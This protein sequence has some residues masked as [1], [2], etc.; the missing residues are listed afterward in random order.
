M[1]Q[2]F[3]D[4]GDRTDLDDLA[5]LIE[6][7]L[8]AED[9]NAMVAP[10]EVLMEKK[11]RSCNG[12]PVGPVFID[13]GSVAS[14]HWDAKRHVTL[15]GPWVE[16]VRFVEG[17]LDFGVR[18]ADFSFPLTLKLTARNCTIGCVDDDKL[19]ITGEVGL[20]SLALSGTFGMDLD[21]GATHA[22]VQ[23]VK[24]DIDGLYL[25]LDCRPFDWICDSISDALID[26]VV[27]RLET[28]VE[29]A[30]EERGGPI[31]EEALDSFATEGKTKII[32]V[33]DTSVNV[34]VGL[35]RLT[36]CG[37]SVGFPKPA[38]CQAH[39]T[40]PG[41]LGLEAFTQVY[42]SFRATN[43]PANAPGAIRYFG[44]PPKYDS[45]QTSFGF[46][47]H[48]DMLNQL[49]WALWYGGALNISDLA[50]QFDKE[51]DELQGTLRAGLPPVIMP[52]RNGNTFELGLGG[53]ELDVNVNMTSLIETLNED[54][55]DSD[56]AQIKIEKVEGTPTYA[57]INMT[58][59]AI[60]GIA[61]DVD[62][63]TKKIRIFSGGPPEFYFQINTLS[64]RTVG[65]LL[66]EALGELVAREF[67]RFLDE[68]VGEIKFPSIELNKMLSGIEPGIEWSMS[69][70]TLDHREGYL[71]FSGVFGPE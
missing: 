17:G 15:A 34:D 25:D 66:G 11:P 6:T 59:S 13:S 44:T 18:L 55:E 29:Q 12:C 54:D 53:L 27:G 24:I 71:R 52:G 69:N 30:V 48:T 2:P 43:I 60:V 1:S 36:F 68:A 20:R 23:N 50:E 67:P 41:S 51:P 3:I 4:D 57:R 10:G 45:S 28:M 9:F 19:T 5:T 70:I 7:A 38:G 58:V 16:H 32:D 46:G 61:I 31:I 37:P 65:A 8:A 47:I 33:N 64:D 39:N 40:D 49:F 35:N 56:S 42:P 22:K 14:R 26:A 62:N 21:N 63:T